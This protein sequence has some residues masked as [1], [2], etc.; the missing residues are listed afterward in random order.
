[1]C[2]VTWVVMFGDLLQSFGFVSNNPLMRNITDYLV[3]EG[4]YE[5][6]ILLGKNICVIRPL[7]ISL[8]SFML[9]LD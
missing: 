9:A 2:W 5:E 8:S 1:M 6:D 4:H 3:D 7:C